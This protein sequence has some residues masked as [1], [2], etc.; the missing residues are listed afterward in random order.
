MCCWPNFRTVTTTALCAAAVPTTEVSCGVQA[1]GYVKFLISEIPDLSPIDCHVSCLAISSCKSFQSQILEG[2]NGYCNLY[3]VS[4][5]GNVSPAPGE[6][7]FFYDRDCQEFRLVSEARKKRVEANK[8]S[9]LAPKFWTLERDLSRSQTRFLLFLRTESAQ[10]VAAWSLLLHQLLQV[11]CCLA[12]RLTWN[13]QWAPSIN[14]V[15][16]C[17]DLYLADHFD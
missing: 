12:R 15:N 8:I 7:Y 11:L 9:P 5:A 17:T 6:G 1:Y 16:G 2:D 10:P 3:N 14:F 13:R 4:V